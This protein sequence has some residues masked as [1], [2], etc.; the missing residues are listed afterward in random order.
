MNN[1]FVEIT[2]IAV[3]VF[4]ALI[5]YLVT[6]LNDKRIHRREEELSL[7]NEQLEKLYGPLYFLTIAGETSYKSLLNKLGRDHVSTNPDESD[8]KEWRNWMINIFMPNNRAE[9]DIIYRNAYLIVEDNPP[10]CFSD[11]VRHVSEME[12]IINKWKNEDYTENF[13]TYNYPN[14]MQQYIRESYLTL[15]KRQREL[16][17]IKR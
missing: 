5:G 6:Y 7:I 11:F 2:G 15:K 13:P 12:A 3:T 1:E 14:E 16:I 10:R 8:L 9:K 17:Y 4:I